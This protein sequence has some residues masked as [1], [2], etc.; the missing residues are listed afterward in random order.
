MTSATNNLLCCKKYLQ[1]V[2]KQTW[3]TITLVTFFI[4]MAESNRGQHTVFIHTSLSSFNSEVIFLS[5]PLTDANLFSINPFSLIK[6]WSCCS[7]LSLSS[8]VFFDLVS[9]SET[10]REGQIIHC[11]VWANVVADWLRCLTCDLR[12]TG[13]TPVCVITLCPWVR[14]FISSPRG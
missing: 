8:K 14:C 1:E 11:Q 10:W 9:S 13:S 5:L 2:R 7:T 12:I 3:G 4:L 6:S